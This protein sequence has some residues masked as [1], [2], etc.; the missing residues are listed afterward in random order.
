M[1]SYS[2]FLMFHLAIIALFFP[3]S[4]S[5]MALTSAGSNENTKASEKFKTQV[6]KDEIQLH[7]RLSKAADQGD[8]AA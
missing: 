7:V 2:H 1:Y 8:V 5:A 3:V 4:D 6:S